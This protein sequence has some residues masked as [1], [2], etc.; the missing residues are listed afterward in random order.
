MHL[1]FLLIF[2]AVQTNDIAVLHLSEE[3]VFNSHVHSIKLPP[4]GYY[5]SGYGMASGWGSINTDF[6]YPMGPKTLQTLTAPIIEDIRG[7]HHKIS[8]SYFSTN[9]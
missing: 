1:I 6:K 3:F 9:L 8:I 2:R 4:Q 7:K 5:P